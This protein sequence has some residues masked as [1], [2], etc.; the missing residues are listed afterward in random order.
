[1]DR[2]DIN[3]IGKLLEMRDGLRVSLFMPA[4]R[5][6]SESRQNP[7]RFKNLIREAGEKLIAHGLRTPEAKEFLK[8]ADSLLKDSKFWQYQSDG[9]AVFLSDDMFR[10]FRL[11]I[12]FPEL[13][14]VGQRFYV[15]PLLPLLSNDG[16]FYVLAISL[17]EVRLMEC[18]RYHATEV[19]VVNM[20]KSLAEA[21]KYDDPQKQLQFHTGAA[22]GG[23]KRPAM[24]HG[25]GVGTDDRKDKILEYFRQVDRGLQGTLNTDNAPLVLACVDYL[26][27]IYKEANTFPHLVDKEISGNPEGARAEEL[28]EKAWKIVEPLFLKVQDEAAAE[29]KRLA[30]NARATKTIEEIIP[31][32]YQGRI[33]SLFVALGS[34]MW[35]RF[36]PDTRETEIHEKEEQGDEELLDLAAVQTIL[37]GGAVYAVE[38]DEMPDSGLAAAVFRY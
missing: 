10:S 35:G 7:V 29:Y 28:Q 33:G 25:H 34:Q 15:K 19:D 38:P 14:I 13:V 11:P 32:A 36:N 17:N 5:M 21:M 20:P 8:R 3:E 27:P 31:A 23:G 37:H 4:E 18:T 1:M 2:L 26:F 6:S 12:P 22:A 16:R 24:F 30:G 9:L